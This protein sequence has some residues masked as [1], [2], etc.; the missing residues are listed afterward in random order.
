MC[1]TANRIFVQCVFFTLKQGMMSV[2]Y[3]KELKANPAESGQ[4][5]KNTNSG[6][7]KGV[8]EWGQHYNNNKNV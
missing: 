7:L 2:L 5:E 1:K 8:G 4:R 6:G 3:S